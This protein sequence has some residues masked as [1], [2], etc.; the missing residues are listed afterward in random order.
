M[1]KFPAKSVQVVD[2]TGAGDTFAAGFISQWFKKKSLNSC[3]K[4]ATSSAADCIC[5]LGGI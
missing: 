3:L 1:I 5:K 4:L 2:T